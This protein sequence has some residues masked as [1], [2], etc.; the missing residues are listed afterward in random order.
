MENKNIEWH[1]I[2]KFVPLSKFL[3][4]TNNAVRF[5]HIEK[6]PNSR[7]IQDIKNLALLVTNWIESIGEGSILDRLQERADK[8]K[9]SKLSDKKSEGKGMQIV[10][11]SIKTGE[12]HK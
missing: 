7:H 11:D 1:K 2:I 12:I 3:G 5:D 9:R 6:R 8:L 10:I 4:R